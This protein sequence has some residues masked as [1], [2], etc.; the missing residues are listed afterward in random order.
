MSSIWEEHYEFFIHNILRSRTIQNLII[1][2]LVVLPL[3]PLNA[4]ERAKPEE[5]V[6][7]VEDVV[8]TNQNDLNCELILFTLTLVQLIQRWEFG[9]NATFGAAGQ[10][11]R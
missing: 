10:W 2:E 7:S 4:S 6:C 8:L 11:E 5:I 1:E 9:L 3:S